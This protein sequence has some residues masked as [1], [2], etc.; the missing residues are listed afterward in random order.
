MVCSA[1]WTDYDNDGWADLMLAGEW[2]PLTLYKNTKGLFSA[3][4]SR[5]QLPNTAGW[6]NSLAQGD[7]DQDGD[8]D[9]LAGNE[10]LN[11]LYGA[12]ASEPIQIVA[13]DFNNDGTMDPLMGYYINGVSYPALPRDALN[14][15]V[16]QFRRKIQAV[17]RLR[18]CNLR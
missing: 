8:M 15:Q 14:Q 5:L 6:W 4:T 7:F 10:G 3:S 11:T 13:K 2:M 9:Y 1:L 12:T 18:G 17:C 16:I